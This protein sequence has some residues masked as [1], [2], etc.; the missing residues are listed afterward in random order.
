MTIY[1]TLFPLSVSKV[2]QQIFMKRLAVNLVFR[3]KLYLA[4][5]F[6]EYAKSACK[7]VNNELSNFDQKTS[8][9]TLIK[10]T[11]LKSYICWLT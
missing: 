6:F 9:I 3:S 1:M 11:I 5:N 4:V 8:A 7:M 10:F 2:L